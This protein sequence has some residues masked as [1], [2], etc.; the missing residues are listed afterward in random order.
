MMQFIGL[1]NHSFALVD[2]EPEGA[3]VISHL[4]TGSSSLCGRTKGLA[5]LVLQV[6]QCFRSVIGRKGQRIF[7]IAQKN[8]EKLVGP[9]GFYT[10]R[11]LKN[12]NQRQTSPIE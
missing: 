3:T 8:D 1:F 2:K 6:H 9:K 10:R 11:G 12:T 7:L 5:T 4:R